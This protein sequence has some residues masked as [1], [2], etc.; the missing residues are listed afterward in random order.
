MLKNPPT[1]VVKA[2]ELEEP[3]RSNFRR[4]AEDWDER[5]RADA[6]LY[7]CSDRRYKD[8]EAFLESGETDYRQLVAPVLAMLDFD[9][10]GKTMLEMGCGVGRMTHSFARRFARVCALDVSEEMLRR[11]RALFPNLN[12][13]LWLQGDGAGLSQMSTGTMYFIFSYLVLQHVQTADLALGYIREMLRVLKTGG[14]Y[15]FQFNALTGH[16]MNWR[17]RLAWRI[18]DRFEEPV[19]GIDLR[20]VGRRLAARLGPG[21]LRVGDTWRGAPLT[22]RKVLETVWESGGTVH[23]APGWDTQLAWC[24]GYKTGKTP[25]RPLGMGVP[26]LPTPA[27]V[28]PPST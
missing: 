2:V 12:N 8:V 25:G 11:A 9:P 23:G 22:M 4:M 1:P 18:I 16:S 21:P 10:R 24:Y 5:A 28:H 6:L 3:R 26:Q 17:G 13:V 14:A 20:R 19:A 7:I 15:C 27:L